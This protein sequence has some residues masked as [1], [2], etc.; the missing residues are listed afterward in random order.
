MTD[1]PD[2]W[3]K[4]RDGT[5]M[6][7]GEMSEED[8]ARVLREASERSRARTQGKITNAEWN[9][10]LDKL[11]GDGTIGKPVQIDRGES[12]DDR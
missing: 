12:S 3:P 5:N 11:T 10:F 1:N 4:H 9:R 7:V 6:T 2:N 8:L